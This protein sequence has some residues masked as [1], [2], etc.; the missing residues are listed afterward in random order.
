MTERRAIGNPAKSCAMGAGAGPKGENVI[1]KT[2]ILL[3]V[4]SIG[5]LGTVATMGVYGAFSST[6]ASG[7]S[8][9]AAGTVTLADNDSGSA[10]YSVSDAKP[11]DAVTKCIKVT[12]SG[13]I[14]SDVR[15]YTSSSIGSLGSYIDLTITPGT[16]TTPSFPSCTG[17]TADSGGALFSGTLASF[18]SGKNSYTNGVSDYP[19]TSVTKWAT[20]DSVVY[21]I[22]AT[23]QSAA[24][25][26]AQGLT[27][28]SHTFSWEARNQ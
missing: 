4:L 7:G 23:L 1:L 9:F 13:S 5:A 24:P 2:K 14:D 26:A 8:Q 19:G 17:F 28:G 15:I 22:V 20:G 27:T 12:Y 21:R 18:G 25:D 11:G 6:A 16:Q 3:T 10:L